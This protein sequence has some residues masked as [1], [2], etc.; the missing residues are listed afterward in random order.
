M[1][2]LVTVGAAITSERYTYISYIGLFYIVG[3]FIS[4]R[5]E[6]ASANAVISIFAGFVLLFSIQTWGRIAVWK[7]SD[8]L[9]ADI[10]DKN[11]NNWR[12]CYVWYY[13]G[14][15]KSY[16]GKTLEAIDCY[17]KAIKLKPD[18]DRAYN[19][20]GL[21][22]DLQHDNKAAIADFSKAIAINAKNAE[23]L[24]NRG[25]SYFEMNDLKSAISDFTAA[26]AADSAYA[27]AYNNRGWA[28]HQS[29]DTKSAL[30]DYSKA[31][32]L[33]PT[34]TKPHF[35]RAAVY[36]DEKNYAAAIADYDQLIR[37]NP[38]DDIA[39]YSRGVARMYNKDNTACRDWK[40]AVD[41]G[42][43]DAIIM[44]QKYCK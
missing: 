28:W 34:F 17:T 9:F 24:S 22:H 5:W 27:D 1:L 32:A 30:R 4:A 31:I 19:T 25:W 39:Y 42:N 6:S 21:A 38:E 18:F 3:Q 43:A 20:R 40:K 44:V 14:L 10:I 29:G 12:D 13:W 37:I 11:P 33:N 41:L 23:V 15:S 8:T 35:N 26:I 36:V 2:Q 16:E 7:N